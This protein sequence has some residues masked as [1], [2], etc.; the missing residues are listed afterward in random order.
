MTIGLRAE[1]RVGGF[2]FFLE[3]GYRD[4]L[5]DSS[6][7]VRTSIMAN[8]AKALD[9]QVEEPFGGQILASAGLTGDLG[10]LKVDVGYRGRFGEH[11]DSHLGG[12][13]LTLPLQ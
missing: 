7:A 1:G 2:G 9:R 4:A 5:D 10:P 3:G 12:I 6:D 13:T 8:T 11:A